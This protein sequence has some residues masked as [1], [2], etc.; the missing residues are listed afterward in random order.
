MIGTGSARSKSGDGVSSRCAFGSASG[1]RRSGGLMS[2]R[3]IGWTGLTIGESARWW[4]ACEAVTRALK[5]RN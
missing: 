1:N 3:S 5:T 4:S 2:E